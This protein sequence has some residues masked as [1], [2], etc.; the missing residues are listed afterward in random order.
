MKNYYPYDNC[1]CAAEATDKI[2]F[3]DTMVVYFPDFETA[4]DYLY[5][6]SKH[7]DFSYEWLEK[8]INMN[9][10]NISKRWF[11]I[12]IG[13]AEYLRAFAQGFGIS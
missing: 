3:N 7:N 2:I 8:D 4:G 9:T 12:E 5:N 6:Y 10:G 13:S 11:T 1:R